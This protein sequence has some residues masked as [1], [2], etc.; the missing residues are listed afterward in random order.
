MYWIYYL[1]SVAGWMSTWVYITGITTKPDFP[2]VVPGN[3][4]LSIIVVAVTVI[5]AQ[6]YA[7]GRYSAKLQ[8]GIPRK[9]VLISG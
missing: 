2:R 7:M 6:W 4:S 5:V 1:L 8:A 9:D 3:P